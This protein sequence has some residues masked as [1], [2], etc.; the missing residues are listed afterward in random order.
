MFQFGCSSQNRS[1]QKLKSNKSHS[2]F[3]RT[4]GNVGNVTTIKWNFFANYLSASRRLLLL[5]LEKLYNIKCFLFLSTFCK[6]SFIFSYPNSDSV[7]TSEKFI[8]KYHL[9]KWYIIYDRVIHYMRETL[10][11]S[12]IIKGTLAQAFST[13]IWEGRWENVV[14][15]YTHTHLCYASCHCKINRR[16]FHRW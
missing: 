3:F 16:T 13:F 9:K 10:V 7:V 4:C 11:I 14:I 2:H 5:S 15:F 8:V 12:A 1:E 6:N